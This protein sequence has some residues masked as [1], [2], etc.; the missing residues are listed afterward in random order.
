M[1][2]VQASYHAAINAANARDSCLTKEEKGP[3]ARFCTRPQHWGG[4]SPEVDELSSAFTSAVRHN[5]D[6]S[7]DNIVWTAVIMLSTKQL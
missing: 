1:A 6:T 4:C 3:Q 2:K 7:F 5:G